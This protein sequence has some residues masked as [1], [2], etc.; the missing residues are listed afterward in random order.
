MEKIDKDKI[1]KNF[2]IYKYMF[3]TETGLDEKEIDLQFEK[4]VNDDVTDFFEYTMSFNLSM[5]CDPNLEDVIRNLDEVRKSIENFISEFQF[6]SK[7]KI[8][9]NANKRFDYLGPMLSSLNF[10]IQ[11]EELKAFF[12]YA[13]ETKQIN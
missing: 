11:N 9:R 6:N 5:W 7:G 1:E 13:I 12:Q 3:W 4:L 8:I 2:E 10:N